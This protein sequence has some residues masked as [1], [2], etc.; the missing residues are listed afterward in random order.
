M[1]KNDLIDRIAE[2][3]DMTKTRARTIVE[4]LMDVAENE[5]RQRGVFAIADLVKIEAVDVAARG[6]TTMGVKWSK[7]A[8]RGLRAKVIGAAKRMFEAS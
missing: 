5:L 2:A 4:L 3:G 8:H 6:G 7:P 1:N